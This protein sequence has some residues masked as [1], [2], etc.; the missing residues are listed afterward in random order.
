ME[1]LETY[2]VDHIVLYK[3]MFIHASSFGKY[4]HVYRS[5]EFFLNFQNQTNNTQFLFC[6]EEIFNLLYKIETN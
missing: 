5:F 2:F 1:L 6:T 3:T 4:S